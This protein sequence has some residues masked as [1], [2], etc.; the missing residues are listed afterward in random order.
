MQ[1]REIMSTDVVTITTDADLV[2]AAQLMR[3]QHVGMLVVLNSS[4]R[5]SGT[6]AGVLTDRDIVVQTL[7]KDVDPHSVTVQ[8]IMTADVMTGREDESLPTILARM[9]KAGIHRVPVINGA[10]Q[11]RGVLSIDDGL[12]YVA[13]LTSQLAE[14]V[15]L[16]RRLEKRRRGI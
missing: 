9:R 10:G 1:L 7:A 15:R 16:S 14:T 11:V 12:R 3:K 6:L 8:D 2:E 4:A 5:G 13:G